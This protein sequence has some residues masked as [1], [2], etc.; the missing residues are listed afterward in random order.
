MKHKFQDKFI[1]LIDL[2]QARETKI[3][4]KGREKKKKTLNES[5]KS[6]IGNR[7][8]KSNRTTSCHHNRLIKSPGPVNILDFCGPRG[9]QILIICK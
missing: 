6:P 7:L 4:K 5:P 9:K 3:N 1:G 8:Q 2:N